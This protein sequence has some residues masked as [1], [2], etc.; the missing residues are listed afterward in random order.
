MYARR[1]SGPWL[2]YDLENDPSEMHNLVGSPA[3]GEILHELDKDLLNWMERAG[4]SWSLDWTQPIEDGGRLYDY[5]T[6][7][8]VPEYLA[9]AREHPQL[10]P[11]IQ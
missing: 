7:Y 5:R 9:W 8:T 4:D 6:F 2:L 11:G 3:A 10:A 1:E